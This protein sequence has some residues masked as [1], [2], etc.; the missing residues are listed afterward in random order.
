M[1]PHRGQGL[2]NAIMDAGVLADAIPK[3][4]GGE[5]DLKQAIEE[6]ESEMRPRG[7][8]EVEL[9]LQQMRTAA[10]RELEKSPLYKFG[11]HRPQGQERKL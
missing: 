8:E 2:N 7:T 4:Y 1:L 11:F 3:I 6:Y 9:T 10:A 5:K